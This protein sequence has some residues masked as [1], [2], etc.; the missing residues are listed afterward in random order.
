MACQFD[1]RYRFP[2]IALMN[3]IDQLKSAHVE[4]AIEEFRALGRKPFLD[5][6]GYGV[7]RNYYIYY[8]GD[9]YD[10]KA[11]AG[12]AFRF[13]E[14]GKPLNNVEFSGGEIRTNAWLRK[15]GFVV[16]NE[17]A[18]DVWSD[19]ELSIALRTYLQSLLDEGSDMSD[20]KEDISSSLN[21]G[22][23]GG[24]NVVA[25]EQQMAKFSAYFDS[26][27]L[28]WI[29]E[30][31]PSEGIGLKAISR[32]DGVFSELP[33]ELPDAELVRLQA[34]ILLKAGKTVPK[35]N[36]NARPERIAAT[37]SGYK[38]DKAVV[39]WVLNFSKGKCERCG[40]DAPF[41]GSHGMPF[42]EVHHVVFLSE[43]G[44]DTPDNVVALC[45]NCHRE[46]HFGPEPD[47]FRQE[48]QSSVQ[49]LLP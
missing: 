24:H 26:Y 45:P 34:A 21:S 38:R 2:K 19:A 36:G 4:A 10:A 42:L 13:S 37:S 15:L 49:R 23:L 8:K 48:L 40:Q 28:P 14:H 47:E 7:A 27:G 5:R 6:Y 3:F 16:I 11:I 29:K 43:D 32:L 33:G 17:T 35:P 22:P 39:A 25:V 12:V 46:A 44:R 41:R 18:N 1:S 30:F 20:R 31:E 9:L